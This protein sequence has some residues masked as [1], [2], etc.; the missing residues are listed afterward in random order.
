MSLQAPLTANRVAAL[1]LGALTI[2]VF[3]TFQDYGITWDEDVQNIYGHKILAL[4]TSGF[5]DTS[6][7]SFMNLYFY[8][9]FFDT[10]AA[11][12]NLISPFGEYETRHLLGGLFGVFGYAGVYLLARLL[13][14]DRVGLVALIILVTAPLLYGHAF[15]NPKD[16]P[17]AWLTVWTLY[18]GCRALM[19]GEDAPLSTIIGLGVMLGLALGTR[20]IAAAWFAAIIG[21]HAVAIMSANP[22]NWREWLEE[23]R[24]R[25]GNLL[26]ALPI[27]LALMA[28]FWPWSVT[29][30]GN[31]ETAVEEFVAFPWDSDV[32]WNGRLI[33]ADD[34][35]WAY[36]PVLLWYVLPELVLLGLALTV[37]PLAL[38]IRRHGWGLVASPQASCILLVAVVAV[39]PIIACMIMRPTLYNGMRHFLFVVPLL[40]IL[41]ALGLTWIFN[42]LQARAR[43][44]AFA[45][46]GVMAIGVTRQAWIA[47]DLHP[48][49]YVY[50][51]ALAG[52]LVGAQG[53]FEL[54]YWG[55][56]LAEASRPVAQVMAN[57][58]AP[59][60]GWKVEVCG[61]PKSVLYYLPPG[62]THTFNRAE[63][64]FYVGLN[65]TACRNAPTD[66]AQVSEVRRR[67]VVFSR[68]FDLRATR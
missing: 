27:A 36:L 33:M 54:D 13:G 50:Y 62:V 59:E 6:A 26:W 29:S 22:R 2:L 19:Q 41:A 17:F 64:H 40:G 58:S 37:A 34:L 9:G 52:D 57:T 11:A 56:S 38:R 49:Q 46:A 44:A 23:L 8:G 28:I 42:A 43:W 67:G 15:I 35:P 61:H 66:A 53:R 10:I 7:L 51:N 39:V 18:F 45:F 4:Y 55:S 21:A 16:A 1:V 24:Y 3:A 68:A 47:I 25:T 32:L 63:A 60:G 14:G 5:A 65:I 30:A 31:V 48:N 12:A 20:V